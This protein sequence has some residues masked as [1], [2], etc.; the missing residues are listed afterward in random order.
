MFTV[1]II[2]AFILGIFIYALFKKVNTYQSFVKGAKAA[3]KLTI[4]ILPFIATI[5]IAIQLFSA[6]G[7]LD[8][9]AW[10]T[11]PVFDLFGIPHEL[12]PFI[13]LKPFSGGGSIAL[14]EQIVIDYG[15]DSYITRVASVIAGS[16]ETVFYISAIYFSKT[17]IK[18]LSYAIPVALLC[19]FLAAVLGALMV[20][21]MML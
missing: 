12:T 1:F 6:S 19:I 20:R 11:R 13:I 5:L 21:W 7:L 8:V 14:F 2:P 18:N 4:D 16:S 10:V 15:P 17:K 9:L 3:I